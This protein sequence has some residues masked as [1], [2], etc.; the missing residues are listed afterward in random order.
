MEKLS[1]NPQSPAVR[2]GLHRRPSAAPAPSGN[3]LRSQ[4]ALQKPSCC[5]RTAKPSLT[6]GQPGLCSHN[7]WPSP[8]P[9]SLTM[10]KSL[11][12]GSKAKLLSLLGYSKDATRRRGA[13]KELL[14][15]EMDNRALM[16]DHRAV[17]NSP[18]AQ[19]HVSSHRAGP[20]PKKHPI[21]RTST[22]LPVPPLPHRAPWA[23][24]TTG[25]TPTATLVL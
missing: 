21:T 4:L 10:R 12:R 1:T 17:P 20:S 13:N 16:G 22:G 5:R 9:S 23:A 19:S 11:W 24:H 15:L 8:T 6:P 7:L 3:S 25:S 2:T 14:A 18:K